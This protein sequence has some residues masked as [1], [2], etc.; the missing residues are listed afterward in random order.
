MYSQNN[1]LCEQKMEDKITDGDEFLNV[2]IS[3]N[4]V[5]K[6]VIKFILI[7][8][9]GCLFFFMMWIFIFQLL[10]IMNK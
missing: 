10:T 3:T 4:C 9:C 8:S 5:K 7:C 2:R 6:K 1:C